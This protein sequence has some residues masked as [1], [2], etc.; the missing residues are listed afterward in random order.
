VQVE[1]ARGRRFS[2]IERTQPPQVRRKYGG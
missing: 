2:G 1:V